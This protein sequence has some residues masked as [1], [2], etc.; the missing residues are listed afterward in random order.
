[1][2]KDVIVYVRDE[3]LL[4]DNTPSFYHI[5]MEFVK[6]NI[7]EPLAGTRFVQ[8]KKDKLKSLITDV[9]GGTN[10][11]HISDCNRQDEIA[12]F[13]DGIPYDKK[14]IIEK[15]NYIKVRVIFND[16]NVFVDIQNFRQFKGT[17]AQFRQLF[18]S[19]YNLDL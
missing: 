19:I 18:D 4:K 2:S 14:T 16:D 8:I 5:G 6:T 17:S 9:F 1:M 15:P 10:I 13:L 7:I 11:I 12:E 3:D